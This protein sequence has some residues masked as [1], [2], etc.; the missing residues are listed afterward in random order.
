[1]TQENNIVTVDAVNTAKEDYKTTISEYEQAKLQLQQVK[2][3]ALNFTES[4]LLEFLIR[5]FA[6]INTIFYR[7]P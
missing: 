2:L 4:P 1:M 5:S 3:E 6:I 7:I